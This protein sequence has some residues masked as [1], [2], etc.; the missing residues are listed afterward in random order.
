MA[1]RNRWTFGRDPN[2]DI[3]IEHAAVS[4]RHCQ[5]TR[6]PDGFVLED[7]GSSKGT[8]VNGQRISA[9]VKVGPHDQITLGHDCRLPWP[10]PTAAPGRVIPIGRAD[11]NDVVLDY[12]MVSLHHAQLIVNGSQLTLEDLRSSHGTAIGSPERKI[13]RAPLSPNDVV[14]FGSLR[15]PAQRLLAGRLVLGQKPSLQ[16]KVPVSAIIFGRD[17]SCDQVLDDPLVSRRHARLIR[18][19]QGYLI[20][21]LGSTNGTFLNGRRLAEKAPVQPGDRIGLGDCVF[22]LTDDGR[23]ERRDYRGNVTLEARDI[24]VSVPRRRL[25]EG[26]SLTIFP[27]EFV[28]LMGPSGAGKTTLMTALNGYTPPSTG[29]VMVNGSDLYSNYDQFSGSIGYV[30]QDDIIHRELTVYQA[31]YFTAK[32]RL[33]AD[34]SRQDIQSRI[35]TVLDELGITGTEHV[36]IGSPETKKGISGGQRKRVNLAMEL[37][38]DPSLLFLDEPTSGL[39]SGDTLVVMRMLRKLADRG[40]TILLTI[41]QPSLEVFRLMDNLVFVARDKEQDGPGTVVYYGPAYPDAVEFFN[42]NGVPNLRPGADAPP[43]AVEEG[44]KKGCQEHGHADWVRRYGG[45]VHHRDYVA[46]RAGRQ[47]SIGQLASSYKKRPGFDLRQWLTLTARAATIKAKDHRNT[48]VLLV[49]APIIALLINAVFSA[50]VAEAQANP[51]QASNSLSVTVFLL[52]LS[53]LWFGCSNSVRDIVGEAAIYRRERMVGLSIGSYVAS[54]FTVLG[55]LCVLQ[56]LVLQA[57]VARGCDLKAGFP[58][59]FAVLL[60]VALVGVAIGLAVSA[61]A[62]TSEFAI[63]ML[64]IVLLP[65]VILGGIMLPV[66]RI[67]AGVRPMAQLMPSRWGFEGLL[68]LENKRRSP[69]SAPAERKKDEKR[70]SAPVMERRDWAEYYFP[71]NQHRSGVIAAFVALLAMLTVLITAICLILRSRDIRA[72]RTR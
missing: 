5:L 3:V 9:V 47:P 42:P 43:E 56:C 48:A 31:L 21:D 6:L 1:A 29:H 52:V 27:S 69:F 44:Y 68:L 11:D 38:T 70:S 28:G 17:P 19:E 12:P 71:A 49:Q 8:F 60:V 23:L 41:H 36:P 33:P 62:K 13:T 20:E 58:G 46:S 54:K 51:V 15:V 24:G 7:L 34:Y 25:L 57:L 14:Y 16:V 37:L 72:R 66:H 65:M 35:A 2:C 59:M 22:Q 32:L 26:V 4:S 50:Q 30:P 63:A 40:K 61:F 67:Q 10:G 64:P 53:A 45:S 18:S 39:S 55:G